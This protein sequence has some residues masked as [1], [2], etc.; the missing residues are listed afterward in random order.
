MMGN[1]NKRGIKGKYEA[2]RKLP[3]QP[4]TTTSALNELVEA[5]LI[6]I[7]GAGRVRLADGV[8]E[9]LEAQNKFA[10]V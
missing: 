2:R 9:A 10:K 4:S 7:D 5:G 1:R 6:T 3:S 8:K